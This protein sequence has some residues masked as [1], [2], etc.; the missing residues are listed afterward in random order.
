MFHSEF[1]SY[2]QKRLWPTR[3][4]GAE[5]FC[6][7]PEARKRRRRAGSVQMAAAHACIRWFH[8]Q[9]VDSHSQFREA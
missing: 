8:Q 4:A 9:K 2:L 6:S 7:F 1:V 5:A 3:L